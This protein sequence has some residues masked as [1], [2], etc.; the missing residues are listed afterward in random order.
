M[1]SIALLC[2]T[3]T[4]NC[5]G[6]DISPKRRLCCMTSIACCGTTIRQ[7]CV[8]ELNAL[9]MN[10]SRFGDFVAKLVRKSCKENRCNSKVGWRGV[11]PD[12]NLSL[13]AAFLRHNYPTINLNK[14]AC[15]KG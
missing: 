11:L 13:E 15:P 9:S 5:W 7:S 6:M 4:L 2:R 8:R 3:S 10:T 1:A 14:S 12:F